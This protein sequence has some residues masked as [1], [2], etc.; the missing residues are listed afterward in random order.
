MKPHPGKCT[1]KHTD[2]HRVPMGTHTLRQGHV[3]TQRQYAGTYMLQPRL[4]DTRALTCR[5]AHMQSPSLMTTKGA[6]LMLA[7]PQDWPVP[8]PATGAS[9][10]PLP[11]EL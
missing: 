5:Q 11:G 10:Q 1:N 2:S 7:L 9:W 4:T 3:Q 6:C 8:F